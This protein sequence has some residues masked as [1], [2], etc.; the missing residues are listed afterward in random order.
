MALDLADPVT[1]AVLGGLGLFGIYWWLKWHWRVAWFDRVLA[2]ARGRA[3]EELRD[4]RRDDE[5]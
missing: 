4:E 2:D 3:R 1:L 5:E